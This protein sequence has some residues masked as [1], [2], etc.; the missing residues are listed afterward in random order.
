VLG[1]L[2]KPPARS[3]ARLDA[4]T[5]LFEGERLDRLSDH[6]LRPIRGARISMV[7]QEAGKHLNPSMKIGAQ[8][9][10]M[11]QEH[12]PLTAH[13]RAERARELMHMVELPHRTLWSYPHELSGGMKQRAL[14]AMAISCR[15]RVLIADEPT[16]ALDA[17]VQ[18]QVL[19]LLLRLRSELD[20]A[21]LFVTH[22]FAVV[23]Q[24]A[25]RISVMYAGS[26]VEEA[27]AAE[28][29]RRPL[30]PY[31]DLLIQAV[32]DPTKRGTA[33]RSI[34]G[35]IPDAADIPSGCP[36]HPRC[37]IARERCATEPP[38][39]LEQEPQHRAACHFAGDLLEH[40][41]EEEER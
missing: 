25:D 13:Q 23:Q 29:F 27:A 7:F 32:P 12:E 17:S 21:I 24:I 31:S 8:I 15:P 11:L 9:D 33:L 38:P 26:I 14:I 30:H 35:R 40:A 19:D 4:G 16:T 37:P 3:P 41:R 39:L 1:L 34:A 20:M 18:G 28:L 22:D 36:F 5:I 6:A 10:E 2:P